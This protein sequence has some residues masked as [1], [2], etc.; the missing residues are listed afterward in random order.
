MLQIPPS[1][2]MMKT[3]AIAEKSVVARVFF[4]FSRFVSMSGKEWLRL[5]NV[6]KMS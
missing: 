1:P 4:L 6:V 5:S 2:P 3:L